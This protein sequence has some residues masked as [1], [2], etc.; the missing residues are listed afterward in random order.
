MTADIVIQKLMSIGYQ[1]QTDGKD[2]LLKADRDPDP[3]LVT[4]LLAEL[5]QCKAEA[6]SLLKS[7]CAAWPADVKALLDWFIILPTHDAPF[8][9]EPH[10]HIV[11]PAKFFE[12]LRREIETGPRGP[13]ARMGTLQSDLRKLKAHLN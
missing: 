6:V 4:P 1:V 12:S 11:G 8:H 2:I 7:K 10:R 5:R 3:V 13:R 9:L